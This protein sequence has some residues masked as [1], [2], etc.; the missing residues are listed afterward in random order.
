MLALIWTLFKIGFIVLGVVVALYAIREFRVYQ[1]VLYWRSQGAKVIYTPVIGYGAIYAMKPGQVDQ[2]ENVML[3]MEQNKDQ[4]LV[5]FNTSKTTNCVGVLLDDEL[6]REFFVKEIDHATKV[7]FFQHSNFGF[8]FENGQKVVEARAN[9]ARFFNFENLVALT[10]IIN[11]HLLNIMSEY[12]STRLPGEEY[13][14]ID[15]KD[16]LKKCFAKVVNTIIFGEEAEHKVDGVDLPVA[17]QD[18]MNR[19]FSVSISPVNLLTLDYLHNYQLLPETRE[20]QKYKEKIEDKSWEIYLSRLNSGPKSTPNL[21][22]L[23][24][25]KNNENI[26][27]GKPPLGKK[28]VAGHFIVMQFAG[29]DTS[30]E[31][32]SA[33]IVQMSRDLNL[34]N[35]FYDIVHKMYQNKKSD[36]P[37]VEADIQENDL[38]EQYANEFIRMNTPVAT[39]SPRRFFKACKIGKWQFRAGDSVLIP[40]NTNHTYSKYWEKPYEFDHTRFAKEN[41]SKIKKGSLLP[42]SMGKRNCIGKALGEIMVKSILANFLRQFEI[43]EDPNFGKGKRLKLVYGYAEPTVLAK[44]RME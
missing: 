17:I 9:Y 23:L 4:Q 34:Q 44:R 22:D 43:K 28:E 29:I 40:I 21:L 18:Y 6:I 13:H 1:S 12:K 11:H 39:T 2:L 35:E 16:V 27:E 19:I 31:I 7:E 36:E 20:C 3:M 24:V 42:F 33:S 37:F 15:V 14:R 26:R 41:L 32:T 38:L 25:E 8:F 30:M 10:N 5:A